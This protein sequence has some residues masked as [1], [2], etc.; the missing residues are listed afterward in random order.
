MVEWAQLVVLGLIAVLMLET[1]VS[2]G[3][4]VTLLQRDMQWLFATLQRWGFPSPDHDMAIR[5][6][7]Q[8]ES[9]RKESERTPPGR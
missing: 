2:L 8:N 3:S 9:A 1:R 4:K 5:L 7:A 6:A